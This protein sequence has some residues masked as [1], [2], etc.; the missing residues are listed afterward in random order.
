MKEH[1]LSKEELGELRVMHDVIKKE[2][3]KLA[4]VEG[5]TYLVPKGKEWVETQEGVV[6]VLAVAKEDFINAL[7]ASKGI[8]GRVSIDLDSGVITIKDEPRTD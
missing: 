5:N 8:Q 7:C 1:I 6:K 4:L 2:Q 3:W